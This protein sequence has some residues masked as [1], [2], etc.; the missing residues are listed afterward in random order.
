MALDSI[1]LPGE[2][3]AVSREQ[4][5]TITDVPWGD[6]S[7]AEKGRLEAMTVVRISSIVAKHEEINT[8]RILGSKIFRDRWETGCVPTMHGGS[9]DLGP[10]GLTLPRRTI[11]LIIQE[12][13]NAVGT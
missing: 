10:A 5:M 7:E 1:Q 12:L 11:T 2:I 3:V 8:M 13:C 6:F 9:K 4:A